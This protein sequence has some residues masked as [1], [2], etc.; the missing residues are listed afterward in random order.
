M[1]TLS[2]DVFGENRNGHVPKIPAGKFRERSEKSISTSIFHFFLFRQV[3]QLIELLEQ[4]G[5]VDEDD[6]EA[7]FEAMER[8]EQ[9]A[10]VIADILAHLASSKA[11][12]FAIESS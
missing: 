2:P 8:A 5:E 9:E 6:E 3:S 10:P 11:V 12:R 7:M 4:N 1:R